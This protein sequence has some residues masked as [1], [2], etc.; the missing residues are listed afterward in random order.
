MG[1]EMA[2]A[3]YSRSVLVTGATGFVGGN[4]VKALSRMGCCV[5][6][7]VRKTSNTDALQKEPV[8]FTVG[9]IAD[10]A[11]IREAGRTVNIVYHLAGAIKA[12]SR[13]QYFQVNQLGTRRLLEILAEVN[14]NLDRFIYISS[15]AAAGP[16]IGSR[17]LNEEQKPNPISWYGESK[18]EAEHE[19]LQFAKIFP[20]TIL[21]PSAVYGPGDRE[22]L[23]IYRMIK[24]GCF[25]TPGRYTRHFSL[26]H[27]DDLAAAI[28]GAAERDTSSG[29]VFFLARPEIYTWEE[30]VCAIS[31]ALGKRYRQVSLPRWMTE[32]AGLAGDYW[33]K[34]TGWPTSIN[35][36]KIK[37]L[38]EPSWLCNS[39]KAQIYLGFSPAINL[40]NGIRQTV[41]WYQAH[42][43]L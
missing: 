15:L 22:T 35:S 13:K 34:I 5:S 41:N 12:A 11:A 27:V 19:V 18:L 2:K 26:I 10:A 1:D 25:F 14:P 42:G 9:D 20:V 21:R 3:D 7:L 8:H 16:S 28:I 36:Q 4:L 43:W 23:P 29:E 33:M 32:A 37:E 31:M 17:G 38:L 6:C 40:E 39:S 30:A 24:R